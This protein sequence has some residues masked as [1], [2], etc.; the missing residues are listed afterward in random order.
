MTPYDTAGDRRIDAGRLKGKFARLGR[1]VASA[2]SRRVS[3]TSLAA[4]RIIFGVLGV[5]AVIRFVAM[6]WVTE[7]YVEPA[8]HFAYYGFGW[9]K[10]WP[11]WGMY[12]HFA[13]MGL[14]SLG[15]ALGYRYRLS[16]IAFFLLFTC[17]ELID[18]TTYLNH[19]YFVS[20]VSFLMIF[21][22]LNRAVSIDAWMSAAKEKSPTVPMAAVWILRVQIGLVYV[23][24]GIAKL[25]PDWLLNAEPLRIWLFNN[26]DTPLFGPL[27]REAWAPY[28]MSWAGACFD[29][30]IVG[31]LLWRRTRP[32]AYAALVAF[33]VMTALFFPSIGMFPWI[34]IGVTLVFF[35]PDWPQR[36]LRR[37]KRPLKP[38]VKSAIDTPESLDGKQITWPARIALGLAAAFLALQILI[39]FRHL[40]YPGNVR[41]TEEGYLFS[42][43]V[44]V[45][46][47]TGMV[48]YRVASSDFQGERLVLP[49]Q[50]LTPLQVER[51]AYQPDM[52]L[53]TAHIVRDE[54]IARG[55]DGV[56]VRADA[57]VAYNGR[58]AARLVDPDV[59]LAG[60]RA[61]LGPK[62][63]ILK[64]PTQTSHTPNQPP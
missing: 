26:A 44:L 51:M 29:L 40:A 50:Y 25:N 54:F 21:L 2:G 36:L 23:F 20:L 47:K 34:M 15:V 18:R 7:L 16:I 4:F 60:V 1:R 41:W 19:Y 3:P 64:A 14:A 11:G 43:R 33:H 62:P 6:G 32:Y 38:N 12:L 37:F 46:E 45:T 57:F 22:P 28:A 48:K 27:M 30:T 55:H 52:I 61:G 31:W 17:A 39:P 5:V 24:A 8:H 63:W 10:P 58:P 49:E 9:V 56:E 53:A 35:D 13:L 42:W 59:D